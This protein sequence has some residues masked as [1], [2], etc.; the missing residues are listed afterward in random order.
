MAGGIYL[1]VI[2]DT[3]SFITNSTYAAGAPIL[4]VCGVVTLLIAIVGLIAA[5]GLW[6]PLLLI[7]SGVIRHF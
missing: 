2:G 7:V 1:V 5:I 6:W 4:I 3:Y